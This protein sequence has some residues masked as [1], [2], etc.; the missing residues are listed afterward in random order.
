LNT[1]RGWVE[2]GARFGHITKG[3]L[4]GLMGALA[5]R[6]ALGTGGQIAGGK[7]A[8]HVVEQQPFGKVL[9]VLLAVG[10]AGY[11]IWRIISGVKD[12]EHHGRDG[13]GLAKRGAAIFSGLANG[14]LSVAVFQMALGQADGGDGARSWVGKILAQPFGAVVIG[15]AGSVIIAAGLAQFHQAYTK[16]FLEGFRWQS[17]SARERHWVTRMGQVGYCARGVVFPIIGIG[18]VR[19][20]LD[21]DPSQ[22]RGVREALLDIAHSGVGQVLLGV[23]AVGF[24][25]FGAFLLASARHRQIAC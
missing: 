14:A 22:T 10:L 7:E 16:K 20:A 23:V 4:Y 18:L 9:L 17:M 6:V 2:K 19:A 5:L 8:A 13:K 21:H 25:A 12:S 24:L 3:V 15:V 11:A 1:T